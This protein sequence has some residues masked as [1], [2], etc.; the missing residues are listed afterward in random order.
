MYIEN[1]RQR[2]DITL[3]IL[4]WFISQFVPRVLR[5]DMRHYGMH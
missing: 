5:S 1:V 4:E 3:W 2:G